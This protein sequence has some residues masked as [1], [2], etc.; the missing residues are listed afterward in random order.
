YNGHTINTPS[1]ISWKP[2]LENKTN[3]IRPANFSF[4][5]ELHGSKYAKQGEWKIAL[6]GHPELGTGTWELYNIKLDRGERQKQAAVFSPSPDHPQQ[7]W[8]LKS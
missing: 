3:T 5:D 7:W 6:Q 2:V 8:Q 1:G 4:A